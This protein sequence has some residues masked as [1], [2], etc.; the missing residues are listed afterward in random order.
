[1]QMYWI[2]L[3]IFYIQLSHLFPPLHRKGILPN[4]LILKQYEV[5]VGGKL[6]DSGENKGDGGDDNNCHGGESKGLK[7]EEWFL[8]RKL[9]G[10]YLTL[11]PGLFQDTLSN[12]RD[13]SVSCQSWC[14]Q[15][16]LPPSFLHISDPRLSGQ[17]FPEILGYKEIKRSLDMSRPG[18]QQQ[19]LGSTSLCSRGLG[20]TNC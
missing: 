9:K 16:L 17:L 18:Q 14:L 6:R 10:N 2:Y 3:P 1:M 4:T 13:T 15:S 11:Q 19:Q 12:S 20:Q 5:H 8:V 7:G